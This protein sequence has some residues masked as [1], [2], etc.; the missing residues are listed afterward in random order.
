MSERHS[1][2]VGSMYRESSHRIRN[3]LGYRDERGAPRPF[4]AS[5]RYLDWQ[6][7][8]YVPGAAITLVELTSV[9][10]PDATVAQELCGLI[11]IPGIW[12]TVVS[13]TPSEDSLPPFHEMYTFEQTAYFRELALGCDPDSMELTGVRCN[14]DYI[15]KWRGPIRVGVAGQP[16][17][18]DLSGIDEVIDQLR[19]LIRPVDIDRDYS[20]PNLGIYGIPGDQF[21]RVRSEFPSG[22]GGSIAFPDSTGHLV[23]ADVVVDSTQNERTRRSLIL[24]QLTHALGHSSASW[25][26]RDS[27]FYQGHWLEE[28]RDSQWPPDASAG[29]KPN[30][31]VCRHRQSGDTPALRPEDQTRNGR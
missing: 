3:A 9:Q 15:T 1:F 4:C 26:Y 6:D 12:V 17:S 14:R 30:A 25:A 22:R 11:L 10:I 23:A 13:I 24:E 19:V 28:T 21:G 16:S 5:M 18:S 27:V 7:G 29:T 31:G 2:A 20:A 8:G